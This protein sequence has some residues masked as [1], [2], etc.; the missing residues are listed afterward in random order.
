MGGSLTKEELKERE[1]L[2]ESIWSLVRQYSRLHL[3]DRIGSTEYIDFIHIDEVTEPVMWGYD[4]FNRKFFV[5]KMIIQD[6][7]ILQT[8]FQRYS[9]D[10]LCWMGCGHATDL[11]FDTAG[12]TNNTQFLFIKNLLTNKSAIVSEDIR[13]ESQVWIDKEVRLKDE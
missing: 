12:G 2:I 1:E 3:G 8:F 7:V 10:T 4:R 5:L 13:P 9:G 6:N 11:L